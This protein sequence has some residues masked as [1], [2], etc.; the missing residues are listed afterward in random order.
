MK[1]NNIQ[2]TNFQ[3][4]LNNKLLLNTLE[5]ISNHSATFSTSVAV[6]ASLFL[7]PLA[8]NLAPNVK[9]ENKEHSVSNSI[10][11][12][13]TKLLAALAI[14]V[15]IESAVK[16]IEKNPEKFLNSQAI[17]FLK[18][19]KSFDF[20]SQALKLSSS[21]ISAVPKTILT[22]SLI[23]V[24]LEKM[25]KSKE[26]NNRQVSF[27]GNLKDSFSKFVSKYFNNDKIQK[28]AKNNEHNSTNIARN[29]TILTDGILTGSFIINTKKNKKIKPE[30]KNNLIY[31]ALISTGLSILAGFSLDKIVQKQGKG[32]LERFVEANKNNPKLDKYIQGIN[33]LR[34]AIIFAF[35]YY[36]LFPLISGYLAQKISNKEEIKK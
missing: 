14:S 1:V 8:I 19:K 22:I 35:V 30:R 27:K 18:D 12:A 11:S 5:K 25:S 2:N 31:N 23:P 34:P 9:K 13:I 6:G 36:G 28:F 29:M 21:L 4:V 33:I 10:A 17:E 3:G 15:P 32:L 26:E 20:A 7:R 16:N 24:I